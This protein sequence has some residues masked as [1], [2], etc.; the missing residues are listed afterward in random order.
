[1]DFRTK[2][3]VDAGITIFEQM[4]V[5]DARFVEYQ[6]GNGTRYQL[7]LM[8]TRPYPKKVNEALGL[9]Q[10]GGVIVSFPL[11]KYQTM[12]LSNS[13]GYLSRGYVAEKIGT[14]NRSDVAVLTELL[15]HLLN[16]K[17]EKAGP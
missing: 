9:D 8:N 1:M 12:T 5:G 11:G 3:T 2:P 4:P 15:G 16:R 10:E 17:T 6:P 13:G 14:D 7:I